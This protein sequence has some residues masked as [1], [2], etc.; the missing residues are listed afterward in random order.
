M[1]A[2]MEGSTKSHTRSTRAGNYRQTATDMAAAASLGKAASTEHVP[3][4]LVELLQS[5]RGMCFH[6]GV[7]NGGQDPN[8]TLAR[9]LPTL[10]ELYAGLSSGLRRAAEVHEA[11]SWNPAA[12]PHLFHHLARREAIS[13]LRQ[14]AAGPA[15]EDNL[16]L[17]MSGLR[18]SPTPMD[19][20][21]V[22]YSDEAD[23]RAPDS[24]SAKSF[25]TQPSSAVDLFDESGT[26]FRMRQTVCRTYLQWSA[27]HTS[28]RRFQL[29]RP[30]GVR[31]SHVIPDWRVD[32]LKEGL[33]PSESRQGRDDVIDDGE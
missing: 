26:L 8:S 29:V 13:Y 22:W 14:S 23:L 1:Y 4:S 5:S 3:Q 25:L 16:G 32:L 7:T 12:D 27:V 17:P 33:L 21:R 2:T 15:E 11:Y 6:T 24:A 20:L 31:N 10:D 30:R 9:L 19:I 18:L 28:I